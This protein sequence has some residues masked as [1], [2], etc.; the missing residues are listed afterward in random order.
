MNAGEDVAELRDGDE[1][2]VDFVELRLTWKA[3]PS[4]KDEAN[5]LKNP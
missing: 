5:E 4:D 2:R 1:A 3:K